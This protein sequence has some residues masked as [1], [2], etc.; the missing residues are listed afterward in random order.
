MDMSYETK[1]IIVIV[2]LL[3]VYPIGLILMWVWMDKW[4]VWLKIVLSLPVALA[5][6]AIFVGFSI[7]ALILRSAV[8]NRDFQN[9]MRQYMQQRYQ[10]EQSLTP[11]PTN[12][13][14]VT[15]T[16]APTDI[17]PTTY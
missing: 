17:T 12:E 3:F 10:Y 8:T 16:P 5:V 1:M 4:P 7:A 6:L 15:P 13:I 9:N 2:L 11:A 14:F